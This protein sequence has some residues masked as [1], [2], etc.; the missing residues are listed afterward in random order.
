VDVTAVVLKAPAFCSVMLSTGRVDLDVSKHHSAFIFEAK[1]PMKKGLL[2][3]ENEGIMNLQMKC[4][5]Q[6]RIPETCLQQQLQ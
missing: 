4:G 1:Q 3:P 6:H 2:D 5:D